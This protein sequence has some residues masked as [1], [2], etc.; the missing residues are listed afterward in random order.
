MTQQPAAVRENTSA[1][2][3]PERL[4]R[5]RLR[6]LTPAPDFTV[7]DVAGHQISL[8]DY[9]GQKHVVLEFGAIT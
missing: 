5:E 1:E 9:K 4:F 3:S 2:Q 6:V 7:Q 8:S